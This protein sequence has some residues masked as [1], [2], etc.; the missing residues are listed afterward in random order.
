MSVSGQ[1]WAKP[2]RKRA[3]LPTQVVDLSG[4]RPHITSGTALAQWLAWTPY[5][6]AFAP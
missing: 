5:Q 3:A 1:G 4:F 2:G 6:S